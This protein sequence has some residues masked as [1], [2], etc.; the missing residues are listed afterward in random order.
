ML[1]LKA[2]ERPPDNWIHLSRLHSG[3][4]IDEQG[5]DAM[6]SQRVLIVGLVAV[7]VVTGFC[8]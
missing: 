7:A 6:R 8:S 3:E 1:L 5:G 4:L 2:Q